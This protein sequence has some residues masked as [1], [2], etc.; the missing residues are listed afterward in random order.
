[1]ATR[2][3][4]QN[5]SSSSSVGASGLVRVSP[6]SRIARS[7]SSEYRRIASFAIVSYFPGTDQP[8]RGPAPGIHHH[9]IVIFHVA[10]CAVAHLAIR[11]TVVYRFEHGVGKD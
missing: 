2:A 7:S 11:L 8:A 10:Q 6:R 4:R 5:S 3:W 9:E 1:M